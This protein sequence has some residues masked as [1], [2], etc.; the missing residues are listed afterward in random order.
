MTMLLSRIIALLVFVGVFVSSSLAAEFGYQSNRESFTGIEDAVAYIKT[1]VNRISG[2]TSN[3]KWDN[4]R[5]S[6]LGIGSAL[7]YLDIYS[8]SVLNDSEKAQFKEISK[9]MRDIGE[10]IDETAI[11]V[12]ASAPDDDMVIRFLRMAGMETENSREMK[13]K[14]AREYISR[15]DQRT[16]MVEGLFIK[17]P[18]N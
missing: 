2:D 13:E 5:G 7:N 9:E 12:N 11:N 6:N 18:A 14:V 3:N 15:L 10:Q 1:N 17:K 8:G 16:K 4:T